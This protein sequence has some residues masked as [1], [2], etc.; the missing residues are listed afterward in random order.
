MPTILGQHSGIGWNAMLRRGWNPLRHQN[1]IRKHRIVVT[2]INI[3]IMILNNPAS[4]GS[5]LSHWIVYQ[6]PVNPPRQVMPPQIIGAP[7]LASLFTDVIQVRV[8]MPK[9]VA[10]ARWRK[11]AQLAAR[12]AA[13]FQAP[14]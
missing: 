10:E 7:L 2:R 11:Q 6:D 4:L 9:V 14:E 13:V 12:I 1:E 5:N 3:F 8:H